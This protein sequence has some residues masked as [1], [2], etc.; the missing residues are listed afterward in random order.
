MKKGSRHKK[1]SIR[2][3]SIAMTG[4]IGPDAYHWKGD[5]V[6]YTMIHR[7]LRKIYGRAKK[8]ENEECAGKS[9]TFDWSLLKGKTYQR[10][11][12]NFW[13]LCRGCH[14]KYDGNRRKKEKPSRSHMEPR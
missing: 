14:L 9:K 5:D 2:K 1:S 7:W 10:I 6:G 3:M 12:A 8:C 4:K 13:M 11:R